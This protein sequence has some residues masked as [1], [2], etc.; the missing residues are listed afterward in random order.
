[1]DKSG[2]SSPQTFGLLLEV[3]EPDDEIV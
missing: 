1:M 2:D 3:A